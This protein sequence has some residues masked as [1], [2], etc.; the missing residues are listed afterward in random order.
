MNE[1]FQMNYAN[2]LVICLM[3][4]CT[5]WI[6]LFSSAFVVVFVNIGVICNFCVLVQTECLRI[7]GSLVN[8]SQ[9]S[10]KCMKLKVK[11]PH[12][13]DFP[14]NT[15]LR[16]SGVAYLMKHPLRCC[17]LDFTLFWVDAY[18]NSTYYYSLNEWL[19]HVLW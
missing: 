8:S 11:V 10:E 18:F 4:L 6:F 15:Q 2:I 5:F 16:K 19:P 7:E 3:F 14:L 13:V 12:W 1:K 9:K 17:T